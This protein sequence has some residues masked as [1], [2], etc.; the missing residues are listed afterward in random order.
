MN[1]DI[2][3]YHDTLSEPD[4]S[5]CEQLGALIDAALPEAESK[6]WHGHPVWF[7]DGN[8]VTGYAKRKGVLE[9]IQ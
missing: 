7:L 4:K 2:T 5:I 9:R 6:I 1:Q 3:A 8:P